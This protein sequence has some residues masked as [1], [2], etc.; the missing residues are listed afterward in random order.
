MHRSI[1]HLADLGKEVDLGMSSFKRA[2]FLVSALGDLQRS[3]QS[4]RVRSNNIQECRNVEIP[5]LEMNQDISV[6]GL[7]GIV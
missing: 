7:V 1:I 3:Y 4:G 5:S 6:G 2:Y